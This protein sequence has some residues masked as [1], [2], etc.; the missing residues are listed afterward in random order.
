MIIVDQ[1]VGG[2]ADKKLIEEV[3]KYIDKYDRFFEKWS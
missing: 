3:G 1:E 2:M